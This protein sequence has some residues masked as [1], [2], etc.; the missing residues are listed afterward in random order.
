M[1][2]FLWFMMAIFFII[3]CRA[4]EILVKIGNEKISVGDFN[5]FYQFTP[6]DDS[7]RRAKMIDEFVNQRLAII[8]ADSLGYANDPVVKASMEANR[9]D[10]IIRGYYQTQ[11]LDKIKIKETELRKLYNQF[12]NQYHLCQIVVS[13]DSIAH[14]IENELKRGGTF[15]SLL[16]YSLDT[17]SPN[18][19]IGTFSEL[20]IPPEILKVLKKTKP[21]KVTNAIKLGDYFYFLKVV[22][23]QKLDSPKYE[24]VKENIKNN[25]IREKA[26]ALGQKYIDQLLKQAKI[27]YNEEGLSILSK[28]ESTL[29]EK[30]LETWVVKKYDTSFVRVRTLITAVQHQLKRAPSIDP[31]F[32]IERELIP[33]LVYEQAIKVKAENYPAIKKN[34]K[35][36]LHSLIYQKFYS[37]YV[38]E[39]VQVDS[40]IVA[41]YYKQHKEDYPD[42]KLSDVYNQIFVKLRDEQINELRNNLFKRLRDKYQPQIN[43]IL[44]AKLIKGEQK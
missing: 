35:K 36:T 2:K 12:I 11:V 44:V 19:D 9:K 25:L 7:L 21:G 8:E 1:K 43:Q 14:L 28:P 16:V 13:S 38:L 37:D 40:Q 10:I 26:M 20:S 6:G 33:D 5:D 32:L 41:N 18:G 27:E 23:V 31:K 29:T 39:K 17:I 42:K 24:E 34:L 15:E 3:V 30:D 4:D 22:K